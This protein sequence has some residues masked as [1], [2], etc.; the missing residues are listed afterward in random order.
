M[1]L[2]IHRFINL[3]AHILQSFADSLTTLRLVFANSTGEENDI[4]APQCS[5][6]S[7]DL[8]LDTIVVHIFCQNGLRITRLAG[9]VQFAHIA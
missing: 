4:H 3:D 1:N 9:S 7:T 6:I 8:L 2:I 5:S